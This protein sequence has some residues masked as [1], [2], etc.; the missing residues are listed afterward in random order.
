M[1]NV[2]VLNNL[3]T[4]MTSIKILVFLLATFLNN[5]V[6]CNCLLRC[7]DYYVLRMFTWAIYETSLPKEN[8]IKVIYNKHPHKII[9]LAEK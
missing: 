3:E 8:I 4:D 9:F 1:L 6:S 5:F 2:L 7:R